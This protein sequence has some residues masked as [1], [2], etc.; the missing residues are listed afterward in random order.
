MK[1]CIM[2]QPS[3]SR[4]QPI[5]SASLSKLK[6]IVRERVDACLSEGV[7][8]GKL[9]NPYSLAKRP[10]WR[11]VTEVFVNQTSQAC[12]SPL[13]ASR[14]GRGRG[15]RGPW[16]LA[17]RPRARRRKRHGG[18]LRQVAHCLPDAGRTCLASPTTSKPARFRCC[19]TTA[20]GK[21]R[22]VNRLNLFLCFANVVE[23]LRRLAPSRRQ[24]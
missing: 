1:C 15:G 17:T 22:W 2:S 12:S 16:I 8:T 9:C 5:H 10:L 14:V 4:L 11:L 23:S 3:K 13:W 6:R 7:W 18:K 21:M 19:R 20:P 24:T